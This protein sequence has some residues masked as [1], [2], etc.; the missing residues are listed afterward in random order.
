MDGT[1]RSRAD[2]GCLWCGGPAATE[3]DVIA[4]WIARLFNERFWGV[5]P[6]LAIQGAGSWYDMGRR[7]RSLCETRAHTRSGLR[8]V[9]QRV[10]VQ[11]RE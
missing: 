8:V 2:R 1:A 9:Q 6:N 10:D 3:E 11:A 5:S 4:R 7:E